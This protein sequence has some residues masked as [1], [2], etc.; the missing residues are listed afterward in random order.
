M[1]TKSP[2]GNMLEAASVGATDSIALAAGIA[3]NL[4]AFI[5]LVRVGGKDSWRFGTD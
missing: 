2:Y 1:E 4:I 5:A 3:A